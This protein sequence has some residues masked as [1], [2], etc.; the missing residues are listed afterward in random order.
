MF[1]AIS[2]VL[3]LGLVIL[4]V[5][6]ISAH[7]V[8]WLTWLDGIVGLMAIAAGLGAMRVATRAGVATSGGLA[9]ALFLLWIIGLAAGSTVWVVWWT[10]A[11]ACGFLILA[12]ASMSGHGRL[13]QRLHQRTT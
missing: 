5:A 8:N 1:G 6:G 4:W 10:F 3:G 11:F 13:N 7:A 9:F 2:V 12:G